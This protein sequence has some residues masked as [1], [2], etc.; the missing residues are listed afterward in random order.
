MAFCEPQK[1]IIQ[2]AFFPPKSTLKQGN[3]QLNTVK[4]CF[5]MRMV[6]HWKRLHKVT[7]SPSLDGGNT[8]S[9]DGVTEKLLR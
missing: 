5:T 2:R 7:E 6:K 8:T 4:Q 1:G 3:F 9:L